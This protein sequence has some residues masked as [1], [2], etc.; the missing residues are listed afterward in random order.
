LVSIS[1]VLSLRLSV[2]TPNTKRFRQSLLLVVVARA[3]I[4]YP[5]RYFQPEILAYGSGR[6]G[7]K[8]RCLKC[9]FIWLNSI[10]ALALEASQIEQG[11]E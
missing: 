1:C 3:D 6:S 8:P 4:G 9:R 5:A 7:I 2:E 11:S 10:S